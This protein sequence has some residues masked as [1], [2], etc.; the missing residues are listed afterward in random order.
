MKLWHALI[1]GAL[2]ETYVRPLW[3][4]TGLLLL[5]LFWAFPG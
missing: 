5:L 4:R 1:I 3:L 2:I